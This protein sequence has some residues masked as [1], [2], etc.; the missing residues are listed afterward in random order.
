MASARLDA[1]GVASVDVAPL[2][3]SQTLAVE[4]ALRR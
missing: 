2:S 1:T 3:M 4:R